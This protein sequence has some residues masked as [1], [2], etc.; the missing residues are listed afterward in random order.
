MTLLERIM[1]NT[2]LKNVKF[3]EL[4]VA[5]LKDLCRKEGIVGYSKLRKAELIAVLEEKVN[6]KKQALKEAKANAQEELGQD[7]GRALTFWKNLKN[8]KRM[9]IQDYADMTESW[10]VLTTLVDENNTGSTMDTAVALAELFAPGTD[11]TKYDVNELNDFITECIGIFVA[12]TTTERLKKDNMTIIKM[13]MEDLEVDNNNTF[14]FDSSKASTF[15]GEKVVIGETA[16]M[17]LVG[18]SEDGISRMLQEKG[19]SSVTMFIG[20]QSQT[21]EE[22]I[23]IDAQKAKLFTEGFTDVSTGKH[24][25]PAF[26][27]P[28]SVRQANM[29]FVEAKNWDDIMQLWLEITGLNT[30][31]NFSKAFFD[32]EGKVV[33]AKL[34]ARVSCRGSNSFDTSKISEKW[35]DEIKK[36]RVYYVEDPEEEIVRDYKTLD[37]PGHLEMITGKARPVTPG[38]GQGE[39]SYCECALFAVNMRIFSEDEYEEFMRLWNGVDMDETKVREGS[40]LD[41]LIKKMPLV[42]QIRHGEKKGILVRVNLERF[43]ATKDIDIIIPDSVR[44]FIGGEW[45]DYPL[46]I[47]NYLKR[48][49]KYVS[50]NAQFIQALHY[51]NPNELNTVII[52]KWFDVL[53]ESLTDIAKAQMFHGI[54]RSTDTEDA[55]VAST[56]VQALRTSSDLINESQVCNW[57]KDQYRKF[58]NNMKIG[59]I[60]VPG[61][62]SYEICDPYS[63]LNKWFGLDIPCLAE[64][65]FYHNGLTCE[66]GLFRSPLIAPFEATKVQLVEHDTYRYMR[67]VII[68]NT[69]DG[70]WD[71]LGGSD[72]DGDQ[73]AIVPDNTE[74]GHV[75]VSGIRTINYDV[76]EKAQTAKKVEFTIPNLIEHLVKTAMRDRTGLITNYATN[77]QDIANHLRASIHFAKLLGCEAI[78]MLHPSA[79]SGCADDVLG[80]HYIPRTATQNG[81]K[82]FQIRGLVLSKW[83]NQLKRFEFDENGI[84]GTFAFD[85]IEEI[86]KKYEIIVEYLRIL[87]GREIDGAKTGV[88]AEGVSGEDFV[89]MVKVVFTPHNMMT[90]KEILGKP[91]ANS[92]V[93]NAYV[94]LSPLGRIHDYVCKREH[95]IFDILENGSNKIFLLQSL[96]T[97]QEAQDMTKL[98][99]MQDGSQKNLVDIMALRKKVYNSK[100]YDI[101][102]NLS[103]EEMTETLTAIKVT[104]EN[105]LRSMADMLNV[106]IETVAVASYIATY[107]KTSKQN[108]G[109]TYA[110][111]LSGEL[112]SVFARGNK[113]FDLFRLPL[114]AESVSI[115][116]GYMYV[117]GKKYIPVNADDCDNVLIWRNEGRPYAHVHKKTDVVATTRQNNVVYGSQIYTMGAYGFK[118]HII[119]ENPVETWKELVKANGYIFNITMDATNRAVLSTH[120]KEKDENGNINNVVRSIGALMTGASFDLMNKKVKLVNDMKTNPIKFN[121]ASIEN[122]QVVIIGESEDID[123]PYDEL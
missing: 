114:S 51:E 90:R 2:M 22:Q 28:S 50:M 112:L 42:Y 62:Y 53:K 59:R 83:N 26:Q 46:E 7:F 58:I 107:T 74:A 3:E 87:Q 84:Y 118:Y 30:W 43:E 103:G 52:D 82:V 55:G 63:L 113:K 92:S 25:M 121:N 33:L 68:F 108:E 91:V 97:E 31:E 116:S 39:A 69:E 36:A 120:R 13:S 71:R 70:V 6:S 5:E 60:L 23:I 21:P 48:K 8:I 104:E 76:W 17:R 56:L 95:E 29:M 78:T 14:I 72:F 122:M 24:Y 47:C 85:Q 88:Y 99:L 96:M 111:L 67:D 77:A 44:K 89:D 38:D 34:L 93:L 20:L 4:K 65:E 64:G 10:T 79:F 110:W 73:C 123:N 98:F 32:K 66:C 27:N 106:S 80:N 11:V 109:L 100:V 81:K 45:K 117:N 40:R 49:D 16:K 57:R 75:I 102:K 94:S 35:S 18:T 105:E 37:R 86:A 101:M 115:K 19:L 12:H 1:V 41:K 15:T 54:I 119:S 9:S 61:M